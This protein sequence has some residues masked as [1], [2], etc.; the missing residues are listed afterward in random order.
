MTT[1]RSPTPLQVLL[2]TGLA[3]FVFLL[4]GW[5]KGGV[6][7]KSSRPMVVEDFSLWDQR[8]AAHHLYEQSDS[9][10]IVLISYGVGCPI[11]RRSMA[12]I[13]AL[14]KKYAEKGVTFWLIDA[15]KLDDREAIQKEAEAFGVDLPILMDERSEERPCRERV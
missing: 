8:G 9:K 11:V 3:I 6:N 5:P 15:N 2:I 12:T 1:D 13:T 4:G 10:A 7:V 14:Q